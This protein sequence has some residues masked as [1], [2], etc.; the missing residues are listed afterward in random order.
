LL[1]D[2]DTEP[3]TVMMR[4]FA[5]PLVGQDNRSGKIFEYTR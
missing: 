4:Q 3:R 1:K 5:R 2:D